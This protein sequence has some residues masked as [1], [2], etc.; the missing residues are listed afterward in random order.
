MEGIQLK[1]N[2]GE[3]LKY[4]QQGEQTKFTP[5]ITQIAFEIKAKPESKTF[6]GK[7]RE[8]C[9][10]VKY[11]PYNTEN[12]SEIFRKRTADE[13]IS[14][15]F[16]TGCTDEALVFITIARNMNIPTKYIETIDSE[17]LRRDEKGGKNYRGHV[18]SGVFEKDKG[19]R[20]IDQTKRK[21]DADIESDGRVFFKEGLDSWDIGIRDFE[22]LKKEFNKFRRQSFK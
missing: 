4:L 2:K 21:I 10:F 3:E 7:I 22:T 12:K 18:Y 5:Q 14:S 11:L 8:I 20:I 15:G 16:V 9:N 19:W 1:E 17:F 6:E 13:I